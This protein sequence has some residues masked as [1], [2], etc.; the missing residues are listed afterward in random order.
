MATVVY[1]TLR[2]V[3]IAIFR[4]AGLTMPALFSI[5]LSV[6]A[7]CGQPEYILTLVR[8]PM[9]RDFSTW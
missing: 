4:T 2:Y 9:R 7:H 6:S 1:E 3:F 8:T 5:D